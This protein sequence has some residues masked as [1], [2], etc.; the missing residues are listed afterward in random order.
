MLER[1]RLQGE[2]E[3][4][5]TPKVNIIGFKLR[6]V[7]I[8]HFCPQIATPAASTVCNNPDVL[9]PT[10]SITKPEPTKYVLHAAQAASNAPQVVNETDD[11]SGTRFRSCHLR[12]KPDIPFDT[13]RDREIELARTKLQESTASTSGPGITP[14]G[15][16]PR[17]TTL[18]P[19][20]KPPSIAGL[21]STP[22]RTFQ[23]LLILKLFHRFILFLPT[24][25]T[26]SRPSPSSPFH[27]RATP[28]PRCTVNIR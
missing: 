2:V 21:P 9:K 10:E 25:G 16:I 4:D 7:P 24:L 15:P 22:V 28:S 20:A 1:P 5:K 23:A 3:I 26:K 17:P 13:F 14:R 12:A 19:D 18:P 27:Q 11:L 6:T 8:I